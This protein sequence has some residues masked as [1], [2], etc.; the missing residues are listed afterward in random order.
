MDYEDKNIKVSVLSIE[1]AYKI[2][3]SI[4]SINPVSSRPGRDN[5]LLT[6]S[7][8]TSDPDFGE[9]VVNSMNEVY[10]KY[11]ITSKSE[12]AKSSLS[13]LT[14]R[15]DN[16][17]DLLKISEQKLS[18]FH[19]NSNLFIQAEESKTAL[20]E[21]SD[22]D[23]QIYE[24]NLREIEFRSVYKDSNTALETLLEQK[25]LL[26]EKRN[27]VL[28]KINSLPQK[29][30]DF[31]NLSRGVEINQNALEYLLT[32]KL[33]F[34]IAEA[35]T[36]SDLVV[37]DEA[38]TDRLVSPVFLPSLLITIFISM[39]LGLFY[40]ITKHIFFS[41]FKTPNQIIESNY[42]MNFL[43]TISRLGDDEKINQMD[44]KIEL[45]GSVLTNLSIMLDGSNKVLVTG[46]L[47]GIGKT[48]TST[49]IA[50]EMYSQ[51]KSVA[52]LD[53]DYRQ[54]DI[55]KI[56]G[57]KKL[58]IEDLIHNFDL[59]KFK[60]H[61]KNDKNFYVIPRV[62]NYSKTS[63]GLFQSKEFAAIIEKIASEVDFMVVDTP[64]TLPVSDALILSKYFDNVICVARHRVTRKR[65]LNHFFDQFSILNNLKIHVVY[66]DF[67]Q[68]KGMYG[69]NYYD[70]YSYKSYESNY[71]YKN[72]E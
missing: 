34:S 33:E 54:G 10:K 21:I 16:V 47:K 48:F 26:E 57:V 50:K 72:E 65:E 40:A 64:P 28:V 60:H 27:D 12:Q 14:E 6:V 41:P 38:Y 32:R 67:F 71:H 43:G 7:Y 53:F 2:E 1:N 51:G 42:P 46:P 15:A 55:H 69:Y 30:Q 66:N 49:I 3:K 25:K 24:L 58:K 13:F 63:F 22:L 11:S 18:A 70:Y 4:L 61:S 39:I 45:V 44:S 17:S 62:S 5:S 31:V 8:F 37:I 23:K 35:S 59:D 29:E 68:P 20:Q 52:L 9:N 19:Q 36:M 56:F